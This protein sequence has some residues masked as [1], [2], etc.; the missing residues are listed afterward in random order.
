[1]TRRAYLAVRAADLRSLAD[2]GELPGDAYACVV[3]ASDDEQDE[4]DAMAVAGEIAEE[5]WGSVL[6]IAMQAAAGP[7]GEVTGPVALRD[8]AA[9]HVGDELAWYATQE[10][11][12]VLEQIGA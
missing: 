5:R 1:M 6:V 7:D 9:I 4:Y 8:V 2:T 3:A 11:D 12:A 10:L